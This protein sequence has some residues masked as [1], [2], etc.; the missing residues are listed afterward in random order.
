MLLKEIMQRDL[1]T[2]S[3]GTTVF[4]AAKR[5]KS[6]NIG[7]ILVTEDG[8]L[9]GILTDRDITCSVVAN[10][11]EPS[12]VKVSEIMHK[13]PFF[14]SPET[15]IY[16]ASKIMAEK[17]IRRLPIQSDGRLEGLI[18]ISELAPVL[19]EETDNFFKLEEVY[20]H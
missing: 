2:I 13:D 1:E 20:R 10:G 16:D 3:P 19:R 12:S 14:S 11:K 18:T 17:G 8:R 6:K 15:D 9:K 7:C 5:M 4:D